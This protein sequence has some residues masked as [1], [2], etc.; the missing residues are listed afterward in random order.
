MWKAIERSSIE[1]NH[2]Q[3]AKKSYHRLRE[4][5]KHEKDLRVDPFTC[6][7]IINVGNRRFAV[8]CKYNVNRDCDPTYVIFNF[9][10]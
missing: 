5:L 2:N 8:D 1:V 10:N 7:F 6:D 4:D 9:S 3:Y